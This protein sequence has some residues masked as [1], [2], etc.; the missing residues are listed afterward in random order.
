MQKRDVTASPDCSGYPAGLAELRG[1]GFGVARVAG[2]APNLSLS[3]QANEQIIAKS[4]ISS[5]YLLGLF[6]HYY[7]N[8]TIDAKFKN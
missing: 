5:H 4:G 2:D 3:P 6:R 1:L 8:P 7:L